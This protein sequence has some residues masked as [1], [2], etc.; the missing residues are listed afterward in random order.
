M[1]ILDQLIKINELPAK[2][3]KHLVKLVMSNNAIFGRYMSLCYGPYEPRESI[4]VNKLKFRP[5]ESPMGMDFG[6]L[7]SVYAKFYQTVYDIDYGNITDATADTR[8]IQIFEI[9]SAIEVDFLKQII[10]GKFKGL[11]KA[12]YEKTLTTKAKLI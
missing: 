6:S 1:K 9:I 11:T 2:D 4:K 5:T 8:L 3:R 10:K 7:E 12:E